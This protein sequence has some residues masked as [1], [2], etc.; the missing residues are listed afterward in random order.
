MNEQFHQRRRQVFLLDAYYRG[1]SAALDRWSAQV[2]ASLGDP[3]LGAHNSSLE[4]ARLADNRYWQ[5]SLH[6]TAGEPIEAL[7]M[8]LTSVV[9]AY[10]RYQSALGAYE[11]VPSMSPLGLDQLADYERCMQLIGLCYLLHRRDLLPRLAAIVDP[12]YRG[13]DTLYEDLMG[14]ALPDRLDLD[15]WY[16]GQ[17]YTPLVH[18]MYAQDPS[19]ASALLKQ[20]VDNWYPHFKYVPWHDGH[21][22]IDGTDGDYFGY[23]AFEA[24]AVALLCNIDDTAITHMV[25]PKDMVAWARQHQHLSPDAPDNDTPR[26]RCEANEPCPREGFWFTPAKADSRRHFKQGELMPDL[27]SDYGMTIWQWDEDQAA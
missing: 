3:S 23:W 8:E 1:A 25:Y 12:G 9:E 22:R 14:Y 11:G 21:K 24:G 16:H 10:E 20:Y 27:K 17:P 26:L 15:E 4:A 7:R 19:E 6:Y 5:L 2:E 13:E 18:A